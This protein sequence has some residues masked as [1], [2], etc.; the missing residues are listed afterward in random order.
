MFINGVLK[1]VVTSTIAPVDDISRSGVLINRYR[2]ADDLFGANGS[3]IDE[4]KYFDHILTDGG[5]TMVGQTASVDS[6]VWLLYLDGV[7][8]RPR[9]TLNEATNVTATTATVSWTK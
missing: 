2:H 6:E 9:Y 1:G 3:N 5:V 8:N 4:L 7:N